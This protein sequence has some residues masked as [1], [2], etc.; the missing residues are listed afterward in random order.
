MDTTTPGRS[1]T[2]PTTTYEFRTVLE[3]TGVKRNQL[4]RWT[5]AAI[6]RAQGASGR[7]TRRAYTFRNLVE[8][9]LCDRLQRLG[10]TE[11]TMVKAVAALHYEWLCGPTS[12]LTVGHDT[13]WLRLSPRDTRRNEGRIEYAGEFG[14]TTLSTAAPL[15]TVESYLVVAANIRDG[16]F[17]LAIPLRDIVTTLEARTGDRLS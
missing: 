16:D 12:W 4:Q 15:L 5:D 9:V 10:M 2:P 14:H 1:A 3:H 6:I 8:V 17:G 11:A 13:L 7:G